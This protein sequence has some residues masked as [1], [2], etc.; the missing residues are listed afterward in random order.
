VCVDGGLV[1]CV[2][3]GVCLCVCV[4]GGGGSEGGLGGGESYLRG[5]VISSVAQRVGVDTIHPGV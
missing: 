3:K 4:G 1:L 2:A 5:D